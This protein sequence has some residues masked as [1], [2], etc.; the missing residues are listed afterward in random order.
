M[1]LCSVIFIIIIIAFVIIRANH[2][3]LSRDKKMYVD[4]NYFLNRE[5]SHYTEFFIFSRNP[6]PHFKLFALL[7]S[8]IFG[9]QVS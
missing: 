7:L 1:L 9:S 3:S 8:F 6:C 4:K 5:K 2:S